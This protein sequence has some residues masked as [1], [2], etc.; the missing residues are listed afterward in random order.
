MMRFVPLLLLCLSGC[1]TLRPI[2]AD[3]AAPAVKALVATSEFLKDQKRI[4][5][6]APDYSAFV[7]PKYAEAAL[8]LK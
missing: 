3:C 6:L 5:A 2:L 8:K 4:D 1:A 7:T